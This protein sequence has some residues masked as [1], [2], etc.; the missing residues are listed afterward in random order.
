MFLNKHDLLK[1]KVE[2]V[3]IKHYCPDFVGD[4]HS[5]LDVENYLIGRFT[6]LRRKSNDEENNERINA[7][8]S[9]FP[10]SA[11]DYSI[12]LPHTSDTAAASSAAEGN[13]DKPIYI[14]ITTAIDT[15][16]IKATFEMVR[17][18]VFQK[19]IKMI[20]LS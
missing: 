19:N 12:D 18:M 11:F 20:M 14:H 13:R 16:N 4:P 10:R 15:N 5:L 7:I 17:L 2:S 1:L 8:A 3:N 6:S 9:T